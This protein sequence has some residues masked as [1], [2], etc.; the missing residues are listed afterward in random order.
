MKFKNNW[1]LYIIIILAVLLGVFLVYK[2]AFSDKQAETKLVNIT[3]KDLENKVENKE[4]FILVIT[5]TGCSHCKQYLPEL[6]RTLKDMNLEASVLN[7]SD[8]KEEEKVSLAKIANFSGTPTTLFFTEGTEKTS[9]NRIVGYAS[10]AKIKE[11]LES[12][13]YNK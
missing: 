11:R 3:V 4:D 5:Q 2:F 7:I 13:G 1:Y 12:L 6:D 8:L 9:L 10:K